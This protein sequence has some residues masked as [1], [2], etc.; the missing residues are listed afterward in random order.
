MNQ[1]ERLIVKRI[2]EQ[3]YKT[4]EQIVSLTE[5][6]VPVFRNLYHTA[7]NLEPN[8]SVEILEFGKVIRIFH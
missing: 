8:L 4:G 3:V 2:I 1:Q 6:S 5:V 7:K